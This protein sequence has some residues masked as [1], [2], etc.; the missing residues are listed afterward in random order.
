MIFD[1][2]VNLHLLPASAQ[3]NDT[4]VLN[5]LFDNVFLGQSNKNQSWQLKTT[6]MNRRQG[7]TLLLFALLCLGLVTQ[8]S[9]QTRVPGVNVGD[10][11]TYSF[12]AYWSSSSASATPPLDYVEFNSTSWYQ[13]TI[14]AVSATNVTSTDVLRF[15]NGTQKS[16]TVIQSVETGESYNRNGL[17]VFIGANL[18]I[19]DPL[20]LV[21]GD[22]SKVNK[23]ILIDYGS[24]IRDTN[25]VMYVQMIQDLVGATGSGNSTYLFDKATGVLVERR[26]DTTLTGGATASTIMTLKETNLWTVTDLRETTPEPSPNP[27]SNEPIPVSVLI[28]VAAAVGAAI[29]AVAVYWSRKHNRRRRLRR[30]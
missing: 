23:T 17:V 26:D 13:T 20:H 19:N 16:A 29:T 11:F 30:R 8:V 6:I 27:A 14:T 12:V 5:A 22:S 1:S 24:S 18:N 10:H 25:A 3:L 28:G 15:D 21:S 7:V 4:S 2:G 9:A